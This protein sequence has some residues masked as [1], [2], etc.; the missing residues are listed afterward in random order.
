MLSAYPNPFNP[1]TV[2]VYRVVGNGDRVEMRVFDLLGREVALLVNGELS[3]GWHKVTWEA[4]GFPSGTYFVRM[5]DFQRSSTLPI[6]L[7]R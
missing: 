3:A 1:A 7:I 5:T 2:I 6:V 4:G